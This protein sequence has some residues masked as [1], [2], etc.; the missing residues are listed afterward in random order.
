[1]Y[2]VSAVI[3]FAAGDGVAQE[4]Q[5]A[6]APGK[7]AP[8]LTNTAL[9]R[10]GAKVVLP[11]SDVLGRKL[12]TTGLVV[13]LGQCS[14]CSLRAV[15]PGSVRPLVGNALVVLYDGVATD[16]SKAL[17][18]ALPPTHQLAY[19]A[20]LKGIAAFEGV[21]APAAVMVQGG[22][23]VRVHTPSAPLFEVAR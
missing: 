10:L 4:V 16:A 7:E 15:Q 21:S 22:R 2:S 13:Y 14:S 20:G 5:R 17:A 8:T 18:K 11:Q 1:M 12:P 6:I 23:A 9:P 3:G 19:V